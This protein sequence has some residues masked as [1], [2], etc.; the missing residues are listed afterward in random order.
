V[1]SNNTYIKGQVLGKKQQSLL[2]YSLYVAGIA[3]LFIA[4]LTFG[5]Y[6]M[7][8]HVLKSGHDSERLVSALYIVSI[9][10]IIV[11]SFMAMSQFSKLMFMPTRIKNWVPILMIAFYCV[12]EG[13]AFATLFYAIN[14]SAPHSNMNM[15]DLAGIFVVGAGI[16]IIGGFIGTILT[17][18]ATFTIAKFIM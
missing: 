9:I 7:Y 14:L 1:E 16:F 8:A 4:A 3:F 2:T 15:A 6:Q 13:I 18:N 5:F 11:S 17:A 12:A 10:L